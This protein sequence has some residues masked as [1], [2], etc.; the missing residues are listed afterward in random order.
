[1]LCKVMYNYLNHRLW[2]IHDFL[3]M[4]TSYERKNIPKKS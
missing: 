2:P 3:L 1:M 4:L